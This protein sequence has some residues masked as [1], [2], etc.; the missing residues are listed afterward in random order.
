[1]I[2]AMSTIRLRDGK[3][4]RSDIWREGKWLDLWSVVH[5]LSGVSLALFL[6][7]LRLGTPASLA[8]AFLGLVSYEMW[9]KIVDIEETPTNR[10]MDLVVGMASFLPAFFFLA[11]RLSQTSFIL[12]FGFV[13]TANVVM[14]VFGWVASQKA[15]ALEKRL[16]ARY[17]RNRLR[18]RGSTAK[19]REKF[20]RGRA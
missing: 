20:R 4:V 3:F 17:A 6:Y 10:F 19:L 11:P 12:V 5:L 16:R 15:A 9:E 7:I 14:S 8:L 13:L 1:M 18:L 2:E